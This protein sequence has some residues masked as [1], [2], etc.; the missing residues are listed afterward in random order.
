MSFFKLLLRIFDVFGHA[1][2]D[3]YESAKQHG[4]EIVLESATFEI[5]KSIWPKWLTYGMPIN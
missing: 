1:D 2:Q 4:N 3:K 5:R